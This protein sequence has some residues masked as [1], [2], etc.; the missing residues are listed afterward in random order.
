MIWAQGISYLNDLSKR[1]TLP[2]WFEQ[3]EY[4][5]SMIWLQIIPYLNDLITNNIFL[6]DLIINIIL[7]QRFA[8]VQGISYL[9]DLSA[10]NILS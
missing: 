6:K 8:W 3:K 1:N 4:L 10:R 9:N 2:Q 7:P 5:T